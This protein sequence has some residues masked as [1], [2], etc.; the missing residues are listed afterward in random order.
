MRGNGT[1]TH[2]TP[3]PLL[4]VT[5]DEEDE[6]EQEMDKR[7]R[8]SSSTMQPH[9][10]PFSPPSLVIVIVVERLTRAMSASR[11]IGAGVGR[12]V[13]AAV[14]SMAMM[15]MTAELSCT[16]TLLHQAQ[17]QQ[18]QHMRHVPTKAAMMGSPCSRIWEHCVST[19]A[20]A[21]SEELHQQQPAC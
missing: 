10:S 12:S 5:N 9:Q 16:A 1:S 20:T 17:Q 2:I 13:M 4:L 6:E 21:E 7:Q 18:H 15:A 3:P 8:A 14:Q 11:Q 19:A